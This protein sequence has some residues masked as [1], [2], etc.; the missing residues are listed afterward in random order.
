[1]S[2]QGIDLSLSIEQNE[3]RKSLK[4]YQKAAARLSRQVY[5]DKMPVVIVFESWPAGGKGGAIRRVTEKLDPR[6][7]IVYS[8]GPPQGEELQHHYL[9]RFW[10]CLPEAGRIAIFDRSWYRRVLGERVRGECSEREYKRAYREIN[11]FESQLADFGT[12]LLKYWIHISKDEQLERFQSR[13]N[14][15]LR[16]WKLSEEDWLAREQWV[17][18]ENAA[19]DML[20][21]TSTTHAPWTIVEGNSKHYARIKVLKTLVDALGNELDFDPL[22][23]KKSKGKKKKKKKK[24]K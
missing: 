14:D 2:L 22:N 9:W 8:T 16:S 1:M 17:Q 21:R 6:S 20:V 23:G 4:K 5:V 7:Y 24:K 10:R 18:Y 13:Q 12:I 19:S 15:K 11:K 3:Y